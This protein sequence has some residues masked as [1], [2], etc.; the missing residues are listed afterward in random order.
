[1]GFNSR[2]KGLICGTGGLERFYAFFIINS[3]THYMHAHVTKFAVLLVNHLH[4]QSLTLSV[5]LD[6]RSSA[7]WRNLSS[8]RQ[9]VL[10]GRTGGQG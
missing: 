4:E 3:I 8:S 6:P 1:M 2:F 5:E 9:A 7:V 10:C